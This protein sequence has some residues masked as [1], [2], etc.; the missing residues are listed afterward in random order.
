MLPLA[1]IGVLLHQPAYQLTRQISGP[2]SKGEDDMVGTIKILSSLLFYPVTWGLCAAAAVWLG[3]W[4]AAL[5]ALCVAPITALVALRFLERFESAL[6]AAR[7][8]V[9]FI[10]RRNLFER[11]HEERLAIRNEILALAERL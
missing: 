5:V 4:I 3:G 9:L 11:L 2:L 10:T 8:L 1:G 7:G 6:G